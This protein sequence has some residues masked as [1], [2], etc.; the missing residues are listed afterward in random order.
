MALVTLAY[1]KFKYPKYLIYKPSLK[2]EDLI[3]LKLSSRRSKNCLP[4]TSKAWN[5][6]FQILRISLHS[7]SQEYLHGNKGVRLNFCLLINNGIKFSVVIAW[8]FTEF[9]RI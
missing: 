2:Y 9:N 6:I 3:R 8:A 7:K 5:I 1:N 4:L